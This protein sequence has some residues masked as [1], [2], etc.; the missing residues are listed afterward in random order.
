MVCFC[1]FFRRTLDFRYLKS[2]GMVFIHAGAATP[3]PL[4]QVWREQGMA[5]A[6]NAWIPLW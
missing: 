4:M 3:Q 2:D 5:A 6:R 1:V